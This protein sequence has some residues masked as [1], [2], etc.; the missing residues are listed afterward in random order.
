MDSLLKSIPKKSEV[1]KGLKGRER[2][3]A[4]LKW[5]KLKRAV[6]L[7]IKE[8]N[9][10]LP[11]ETNGAAVAGIRLLTLVK[12]ITINYSLTNNSRLPGYMD[13]TKLLGENL[14]SRQPGFAY[15]F[16]KMPTE[17]WL[18]QKARQ[19]I[20]SEDPQFNDYYSRTYTEGLNLS[21]ELEPVKDLIIDLTATKSFNKNY[22][23]LFKDTAGT[24]NFEHLSPYSAGGFTVSYASFKS[25]FSKSSS[26]KVSA[27]FKNFS[28]YRTIISKR[29][30][31]QNSYYN[32]T[33]SDDGYATGYGRYA[34]NVLIPA[35]IAAY[36][37]KSPDK[38]GLVKEDNPDI[39][40]NP[41]GS[42]FP[43]PNWTINYSGLNRLGNLSN[44]F[45]GITITNAYNGSLAMNSFT[46]AL[47]F[48][49]PLMRG[50]PAFIDST[51]GNY[52][53]YFLI[54]NI[55]ISENFE[56]LIGLNLT[57]VNQ[58][59]IQ[60]QYSKSKT[61]SLS[62]IDYQVSESDQTSYQLGFNIVKHN[63]NLPFA[64]KP[65]LKKGQP[66][67]VGNDL[68]FGLNMSMTNQFTS[69]TTL[70]QTSNYSTGGQKVWMFSPSVN[71]VLNNRINLR[72][73]LYATANCSIHFYCA[74]NNG[75]QCRV[76]N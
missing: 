13:S 40:T 49:D 18:E 6:K 44:I 64:P 76:G 38:V 51:S 55:T 1:V 29:L 71:Y 36:T 5:R 3:L 48:Q 15:I 7:A 19:H 28:D 33:T 53:P 31:A 4:L 50:E 70:D 69:N 24:G 26:G 59:N 30:A 37:G 72:L 74:A 57:L 61:L 39:K 67:G 56:P 46:S 52:V 14:S 73:F 45:S 35:F 43:K 11:Q 32:G 16:G 23:E 41:L 62:L 54:P 21:A 75:Y 34:Q 58:S 9:A 60:F 47:N 66:K 8:Q 2:K 42:I 63:V 20:I 65:K 27:E 25:L 12:S 17:Q 10:K 68:S 22:S